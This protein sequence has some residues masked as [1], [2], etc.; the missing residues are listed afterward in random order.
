MGQELGMAWLSGTCFGSAMR[1][2]A[3]SYDFRGSVGS[4]IATSV[5]CYIDLLQDASISSQVEPV[6][7]ESQEEA[8]ILIS[9]KISHVIFTSSTT[10]YFLEGHY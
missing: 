3:S 1:L 8:T 9:T 2:Q 10:F 7:K 6:I 4:L 5:P